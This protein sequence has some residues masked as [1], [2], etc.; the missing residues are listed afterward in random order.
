MALLGWA[1]G[2]LRRLHRFC[3]TEAQ[4][5]LQELIGIQHPP[6]FRLGAA[7]AMIGIG[8]QKLRLLSE[9]RG[10]LGQRAP[11]LYSHN[12]IG[13]YGVIDTP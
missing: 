1:V 2:A 9:R 10:H 13:V 7:V 4:V 11:E 6:E 8:M 3:V 5:F 12:G